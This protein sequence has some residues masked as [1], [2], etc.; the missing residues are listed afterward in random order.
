MPKMKKVPIEKA[1]GYHLVHDITVIRKDKKGVLFKKGHVIREE[2]IPLLKQVG[3]KF[4][5]VVDDMSLFEKYVHEDDFSASLAAASIDDSLYFSGPSEG[6]FSVFSKV[7]GILKVNVSAL[8]KLNMING[9][10]FS[11]QLTNTAVFKNDL[12]AIIGLGPLFT[13][14]KILNKALKIA[15]DN[16]PILSVK[17][18]ND[19]KIGL[20]VTGNEIY[21]GLI[22]DEF[23]DVLMS[24]LEKFGLK[25]Y[26]RVILPDNKTLIRNK[27]LSFINEGCDIIIVSGGMSVD[28][29]DVT[30]AAIRSTGA[31]VIFYGAPIFPGSSIMLAYYNDVAIYG[32]TASPIFYDKTTLDIFLPRFIARDKITRKEIVAMGHGGLMIESFKNKRKS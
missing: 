16:Y 20:I 13:T 22:K 1:V 28:P 17:E 31:K 3:K 6:K 11:T 30:P 21:E 27:I 7:S 25:I 18:F 9:V 19:V 10:K 14:K 26:K 15:K 29:D 8:K 32:T 4:I 23:T 24:K 5:Y 12:V 2:D